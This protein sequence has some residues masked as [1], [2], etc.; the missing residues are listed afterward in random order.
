VD[1][2]GRLKQIAGRCRKTLLSESVVYNLSAYD[3]NKKS[4]TIKDLVEVANAEIQALECIRH[5]FQ[6]NEILS[7]SHDKIRNLIIEKALP[8]EHRYVRINGDKP[9]ISYL[10]IDAYLENER[11][12][13]ELYSKKGVLAKILKNEGHKVRENNVISKVEVE[14]VDTKEAQKKIKVSFIIGELKKLSPDK[15]PNSLFVLKGLNSLQKMILEVYG[16]LYKWIDNEQL[17]S[18]LEEKASAGTDNREFKNF[19]SSAFYFILNPKEPYKDFVNQQIIVGEVYT[20]E[21]LHNKWKDIFMFNHFTK[22]IK[23]PNMA[24]KLTNLHFKTTK[25]LDR[26]RKPLGHKI[27]NDNPFRLKLIAHLPL[28]NNQ[29]YMNYIFQKPY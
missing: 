18:L 24:V 5:N 14:R 17:L 10:N 16:L 9:V 28:V 27:V 11:V 15:E 13:N 2:P 22:K 7:L 29:T 23:T 19:V 21:E 6:S 25:K 4:L 26:D 20:I 1:F 12:K 3:E 8:D